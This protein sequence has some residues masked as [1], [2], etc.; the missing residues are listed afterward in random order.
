[1]EREE[2]GGRGEEGES[3]RATARKARIGIQEGTGDEWKEQSGE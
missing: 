1:M 3:R 2:R